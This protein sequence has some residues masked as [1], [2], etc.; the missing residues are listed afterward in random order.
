MLPVFFI[1]NGSLPFLPWIKIPEQVSSP[2]VLTDRES[3]AMT[4]FSCLVVI[5]MG[6]LAAN[7]N[8]FSWLNHLVLWGTIAF[9][10]TAAY[11]MSIIPTGGMYGLMTELFTSPMYWLTVR[12][13]GHY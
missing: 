12:R 9:F 4:I 5:N 3:A 2:H 8:R 11:V 10:F 13:S 6:V 7:T 1:F